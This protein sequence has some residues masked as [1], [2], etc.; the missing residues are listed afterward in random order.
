MISILFVDDDASK[1]KNVRNSLSELPDLSDDDIT[2]VTDRLSAKRMLTERQFDLLILDLSLPERYGDTPESDGGV[3]FLEEISVDPQ[4]IAPFHIIGLTAF[5]ELGKEYE[6]RFNNHVWQIVFYEQEYNRWSDQLKNHI[7]YLIKSKLELVNPSNV[8]YQYD[9]AIITA[10]HKVELEEVLKLD[11]RWTEFNISNDHTVYYKGI[12]TKGNKKVTVIAASSDQMGLTAAT[13]T[14][15]KLIHNFRPKY[16]VMTGIAAGIKGK[17]NFGDILVSD[18]S[19]DYG[20]GKI[21]TGE[22]GTLEFRQDPRPLQLKPEIKSLIQKVELNNGFL[23]EI[24]TKWNKMR[25]G[26]IDHILN[27]K[28]GPL[29]SGSYVIENIDKVQEV[30][31]QQRKLIGIDMESYSVFYSAEYCTK[32]RPVAMSIKSICDFGDAAKN[33]NYQQY[34]AFTSA[35]FLY[36]LAVDYLDFEF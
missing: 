2:V 30:I 19:W 33:D 10:L 31:D 25:G 3:K 14:C 4:L 7:N 20:S 35:N 15:Q 12:F 22:D 13:L 32:P 24:L 16:L 18:L 9:L 17:G 11:G 29:A 1:I 36:H 27:L 21:V 26:N 6:D 28:M 8:K 23:N 5:A 34:A